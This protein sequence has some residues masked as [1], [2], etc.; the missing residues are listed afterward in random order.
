[1]NDGPLVRLWQRGVT[2]KT[3]ICFSEE[4]RAGR[5]QQAALQIAMMSQQRGL[6]ANA[7]HASHSEAPLSGCGRSSEMAPLV[8]RWA[9]GSNPAAREVPRR[10]VRMKKALRSRQVAAA[11]NIHLVR[12]DGEGVRRG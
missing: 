5:R 11:K 12:V 1:M 3:A 9:G 7:P 10:K 6:R 8:P 4:R 2:P